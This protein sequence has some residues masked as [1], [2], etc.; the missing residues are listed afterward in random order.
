MIISYQNGM[1]SHINSTAAN[2]RTPA[3]RKDQSKHK[4]ILVGKK[5]KDRI[6]VW[7]VKR[8][9]TKKSTINYRNVTQQQSIHASHAHPFSCL[10][11]PKPTWLPPLSLLLIKSKHYKKQTFSIFSSSCSSA[12]RP[13]E[14]QSVRIWGYG[15]FCCGFVCLFFPDQ[16]RT[17]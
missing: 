15:L 12:L 1:H 16:A 8:K 6:S 9:I 11:L 4:G 3:E 5:L 14:F 7:G 10:S 13:H 2:Q 17:S